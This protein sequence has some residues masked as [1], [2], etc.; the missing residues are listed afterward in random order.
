MI[1]QQEA[2]QRIQQANATQAQADEERRT[3]PEEQDSRGSDDLPTDCHVERLTRVFE[4]VHHQ[5]A[6]KQQHFVVATTTQAD[7]V[8]FSQT[9]VR[10]PAAFDGSVKVG[11]DP[12]QKVLIFTSQTNSYLGHE[13]CLEAVES[14]TPIKVGQP[15]IDRAA[16][17]TEF[18]AELVDK[19]YRAWGIL[20]NTI[21]YKTLLLQVQALE[22]SSSF[23]NIL[24][25]AIRRIK[26]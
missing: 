6:E 2:A 25:P 5:Q 16:F 9:M 22:S 21:M 7:N 10:V 26:S 3:Q 15:N 19:A 17:E 1:K 24:R 8:V 18:G 12:Q 23:Q 20:M 11:E 4:V 14:P 13:R